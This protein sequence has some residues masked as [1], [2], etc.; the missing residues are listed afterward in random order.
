MAEQLSLLESKPEEPQRERRRREAAKRI[1]E[2]RELIRLHDHYYYVEAQ[3]RIS[4]RE[5]DALFAE[6][7]RLEAEFPELITPD[8]PTQRVGGE[9]L[10]EFPHV[11][12]RIPMLS[13]DN[14]YSREEVLEFDRRVRELLEGEPY[15]YV[16]ELKY[17]GVSV[18]LHYRD[19][20]FVL[21]ASRGDGYT[22]DDIT[23]NLRTIRQLPLRVRPVSYHGTP[24][25]TFEVRGE[26]YLLVEDFLRLNRERVEAGE[27]PFANPRN[28][29]AGTLKLLDPREVARRP[30]RLVCYYLYSDQVELVS[31]SENLQLLQQL[32]FPTDPHWRLC[33]TL[34]EVFAFI[35]HWE[36]ARER[37][38]FQIDG[39]VLK[40]DSLRQQ[41]RLGT[42]ARAPRWAIAY[43][44]EAKKATTVLRDIV[45]QVGRTGKVTPVAELEPVFLAGSTISRAT[46]H[47]ADYIAKLDLRIGD[48]V[49]VEKGGEVIPKV[50]GVVLERRPP[51]AQPYVFP[52][53]C[54]CPLQHP[55]YRPPGE[56]DYYCDH[57]ECPWQIRRRIEHFASRRAM[58][59]QGMGERV[60]D[61]L[62]N[63]GFLRSIADIYELHR[64]SDR[65]VEL[66]GW[67]Q[68]RVENLLA[69]IEASKERPYHRVLFALGIRFV[70]EETAKLLAEAF[71]SMDALAQATMDDLLAIHGVGEQI[72]DS[73]YRFFRD[74]RNRVLLERLR[75]AGL[76]FAT[77]HPPQPASQGFFAGKTFVLTG[78]LSSMTRDQARQAIELRGGRTTDT[79]SR[80]T[81]YLIVGTRPGSK[82]LRAQ[83]LGI[84][85]LSEEEFLR[86]LE[87]NPPGE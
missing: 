13:L 22:G 5:Y 30:L 10:K 77:E 81:D 7:K 32:G 51:E 72:A 70:G 27:R 34:D 80:R 25:Y 44:Y 87:A 62:V 50:S 49:I 45:L 58:D 11:Q 6:L 54:P 40:V 76:H 12:H 26:V 33:E 9:P 65:L 64:Y 20:T 66:E 35:D 78:E 37:L 23:Q 57:L 39:I 48:T 83:Q 17:D 53:V 19:G 29:A 18:S 67:G 1:Q 71:P 86:L 3:P 15:R 43:K 2:L 63:H 82:L 21:G 47:N 8:S 68:K 61:Q 84:P 52:E 79:V 85:Q 75:Q 4:D 31:Q 14:T 16:A 28:L 41:Q 56:V 38:P 60:V 55:L 59:I 42:V 74:E 69:A 24:L 36:T 73:V 46:L